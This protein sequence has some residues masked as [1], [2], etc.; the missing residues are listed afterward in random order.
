M[1]IHRIAHSVQ[2]V[3]H[4][5]S[6]CFAQIVQTVKIPPAV[7]TVWGVMDVQDVKGVQKKTTVVVKVTWQNQTQ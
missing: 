4:V 7:V 1:L 6:V 2:I 3:N 5:H